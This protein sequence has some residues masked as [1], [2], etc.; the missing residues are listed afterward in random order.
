MIAGNL[1]GTFSMNAITMYME[2][3]APKYIYGVDAIRELIYVHRDQQTTRYARAHTA[4]YELL[5]GTELSKVDAPNMYLESIHVKNGHKFIPVNQASGEFVVEGASKELLETTKLAINRLNPVE[6]L[7]VLCNF[8]KNPGAPKVLEI[9]LGRPKSPDIKTNGAMIAYMLAMFMGY[10]GEDYRNF[11]TRLELCSST[12]TVLVIERHQDN[13]GQITHITLGRL[14][15]I[16]V[17]KEGVI[18]NPPH[19]TLIANRSGSYLASSATKEQ[20]IAFM[21]AILGCNNP[22]PLVSDIVDKALELYSIVVE[23][24]RHTAIVPVASRTNMTEFVS[25]TDGKVIYT[26]SNR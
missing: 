23:M 22:A 2:R 6:L 1:D 11:Y 13:D 7:G 10:G 20:T 8:A 18:I 17:S 19:G 14:K 3:H 26:T 12:P 15:L 16:T 24:T 4:A 5:T 9:E 25:A 21:G